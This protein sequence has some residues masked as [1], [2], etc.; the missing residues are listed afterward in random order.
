[1][2]TGREAAA[3]SLYLTVNNFL[4]K[5]IGMA[6]MII[7]TSVLGVR[8]YGLYILLLSIHGL[9]SSVYYIGGYEVITA[10]VGRFTGQERGDKSK[11]LLIEYL[12]VQ[13]VLGVL[14]GAVLIISSPVV[15]AKYGAGVGDALP[16]IAILLFLTGLR[17]SILLTLNSHGAFRTMVYLRACEGLL[18]LVLIIVIVWWQGAGVKGALLA[19]ALAALAAIAILL[20]AVVGKVS[21]LKEQPRHKK[22]LLP[23]I[24]KAHGKWSVMNSALVNSTANLRLWIITY[25]IS[26]EAVAVYAVAKRLFSFSKTVMP[27]KAVLS[28]AF[29]HNIHDS[30]RVRKYFIKSIKYKFLLSGVVV[31][32]GNLVASPLVSTLFPKYYPISVQI[33]RI[34]LVMM[35]LKGF[36]EVFNPFFHAMQAQKYIFYATLGSIVS[37]LVFCP[38]LTYFFGVSGTAAEN[39][40]SSLTGISLGYIFVLKLNPLLRFKFREL[41]SFDEEDRVFWDSVNPLR[42]LKQKA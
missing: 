38:L 27:L 23:G 25:I 16:F 8:D 5:F 37:L 7:L 10:D 4:L 15:T 19:D 33:F 35:F 11:A 29:S 32:L 28:P 21:Y 3:G 1:M 22:L 41:I 20:P 2:V 31:V 30:K 24:L 42:R 18:R 9:L 17:N 14:S 39:V 12:V 13:I 34:L 26:V 36:N 6:A 40:L